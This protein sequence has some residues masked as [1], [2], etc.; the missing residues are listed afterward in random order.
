LAR[1]PLHVEPA[2]RTREHL[3]AA[4][5]RVPLPWP[6]RHHH[7]GEEPPLRPGRNAVWPG[8]GPAHGNHVRQGAGF[9]SQGRR[10]SRAAGFFA[11][12]HA[13]SSGHSEATSLSLCCSV[14]LRNE[15]G[16][17][18]A[19]RRERRMFQNAV[20]SMNKRTNQIRNP[21]RDRYNPR[22]LHP[23]SRRGFIEHPNQN[24]AHRGPPAQRSFMFRL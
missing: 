13:A 18:G 2:G 20:T 3:G 4:M 15:N 16:I 1:R 14:R 7:G 21:S 5:R 9:S 19:T 22:S 23:L 11:T 6:A 10:R 17:E 24:L 12:S 8:T